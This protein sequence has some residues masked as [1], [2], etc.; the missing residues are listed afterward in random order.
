MIIDAWPDDNGGIEMVYLV[1]GTAGH[2]DHGK[3]S[4]V[5]VLSGID[6]DRLQEEK[7]RGITVELGFAYLQLPGGNTVALVDVP[8]HERFI[9][10]M[11][12][13][14]A[15]LDLALLIIAADEGIM[16][17]TQ[18][19]FAILQLLEVKEIIVVI[20]KIDLV[21]PAVP[22]LLKEDIRAFLAGTS[23]EGAPILTFSAVSQAGKE[24][25]LQA[26]EK[27]VAAKAATGKDDGEVRLP[28]DR[29]F[30]LPGFGTVVTGTLLSGKIRGGD[31]LFIPLKGKRVR[32]RNI[33]VH[34]EFAESAQA[35][36]RVAVN[37]AGVDTKE[38]ERGDTLTKEG[39]LTPTQR[40]DVSFSLLKTAAGPLR[41]FSRIR[42][43][44]GT[45]EIIGRIFFWDREELQPGEKSF[46]QLVLE[47]P[48]VVQKDDRYVLRSYS[49]L[50]TLGGGKIIEP[51]A[52]KHKKRDLAKALEEAAIKAE[53]ELKEIILLTLAQRKKPLSADEL[54][55]Q[56]GYRGEEVERI[57]QELTVNDDAIKG[58]TGTNAQAEAVITLS[59][60]EREQVYVAAS[61]VAEKESALL[62]TVKEYLQSNPLEPGIKKE[63]LRSRL[64]NSL[65]LNEFNGL[66]NY[67]AGQQKI[68]IID[69]LFIAPYGVRSLNGDL[70]KQI[71]AIENYY[72]ACGWQ[73][74]LWKTVE[75]E[76]HLDGK[77]SAPLLR[78][79][80]RT[81]DL[82]QLVA[83][84]Y[85]PKHLL[86]EGQ[87]KLE[88]WCKQN[89]DITVAQFRDL[90][91]TSRK[92]AVP[93]LEYLDRSKITVRNGD[94]RTLF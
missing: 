93:F 15:G 72:R 30:A 1:V 91:G 85:L 75:Q 86:A 77:S 66:L 82:L 56:T 24:E 46:A 60:P 22:E 35:G 32:V 81:G 64:F 23:Y 68:V 42:F 21:E 73:V 2:I 41:H 48:A 36:Q 57:L 18:E 80:L 16:P 87:A 9:K 67:W 47:K 28:I 74:P 27:A 65:E 52:R 76:L 54:A 69:G 53:G 7:K 44:Q 26:L 78:Y 51:L 71:S 33:Q 61:F 40:L 10:N 38:I 3:S 6:P 5:K 8:G 45:A 4:L 92:V 79:F 83:D 11:L 50:T 34:N 70:Q 13:G 59:L 62:Q 19:H 55:R 20:T 84:L 12:A 14:V 29:V 94:K 37:L 31:Q 39:W 43:Y 17:Q 90:V 58:N 63:L 88:E 49:P 25:L 89:G